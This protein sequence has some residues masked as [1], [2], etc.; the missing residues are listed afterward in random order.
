MNI[1]SLKKDPNG[2]TALGLKSCSEH[3]HHRSVCV[4]R[5]IP[6]SCGTQVASGRRKA[7]CP[8]YAARTAAAEADLLLVPYG[9]LLTQVTELAG[10][11][12]CDA[13]SPSE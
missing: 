2:N 10:F 6:A 3:Q 1:H 12:E 4:H 11:Q 5:T 8:Y 7:V 13:A 9:S